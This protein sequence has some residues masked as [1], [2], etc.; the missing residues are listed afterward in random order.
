MTNADIRGAF[1]LTSYPFRTNLR[2]RELYV[3]KCMRDINDKISFAAQSGMY[4]VV[5]GE[6][7]AG[8][9]TAVEYA[10]SLLPEKSYNV[11][12]LI[13]S[14]CS[15]VELMRQ[16][17]TE[18]GIITRTSQQSTMLRYISEGYAAMIE[19][20]KSPVL[21]IDEAHLFNS[22]VFT[23]MHIISQTKK[24]GGRTVPVILCGQESLFDKLQ[25]PFVKPLMS[26]VIDGY[27]LSGMSQAECGEYINHHICTI[28]GGKNDVFDETAV[29]AVSQASGGIPRKIN[30]ICLKAMGIAMEAGRSTVC[31]DD[32]RRASRKW[33]D[34]NG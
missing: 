33:W 8:K 9:S 12:R 22:D 7:G 2:T 30:N 15:F 34:K 1:G 4:F 10:L 20:G 26:R 19:S 27:L 28:A 31:A 6:V 14:S 16:T 18:M 23:Q 25:S 17:M 24:I 11:I 32:V 29:I 5:I 3:R 13:G 21:A